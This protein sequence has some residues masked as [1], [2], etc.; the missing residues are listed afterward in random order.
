MPGAAVGN[1]EDGVESFPSEG[2]IDHVF[3]THDLAPKVKKAWI[4][5]G[6]MASDHWPLFVEFDL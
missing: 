6:T 5:H 4:D 3:V 1:S 2:R